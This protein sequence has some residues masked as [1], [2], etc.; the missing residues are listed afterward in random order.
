MNYFKF[1]RSN[2]VMVVFGIMMTALSSFGQTFLLALYVPFLISEFSLSNSSVSTFYGVATIVSAAMLPKVGKL[3]DNVPIKWF[4]IGATLLFCTALVT[5]SLAK[6]W[7]VIPISFL[8]LRL[9]GQGLYSH[10][11]ITAMSRYFEENRGKAISLAS[12]GHPLGQAVLPAIILM[13]IAKIGWRESLWLN[14]GLVTAVVISYTLFVLKEKHLQ[15][16]GGAMEIPEEKTQEKK[17]RQRDII[18]SKEFWLLAPN[19]FFIPFATTGLFFYQISIV[20]FKGW[21]E[22]MVAAGLSVYAIA[23][24]IS[25]LTAGPLID[26][27]RAKTFFPWYL[28]PFFIAILGLWL[29]P[30][31]W[32]MFVYM[33]LMGLSVGFGSA[34]LAALQVEFFGKKFIGSVRSIFT[35]IM[36]LSSALGPALYG[37]ILDA[38]LGWDVVLPINLI[39]LLPII[40]QSFRAMPGFTKAKWRFKYKRLKKKFGNRPV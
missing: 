31:I 36:V 27:Y 37:V 26:K 15:P 29:I 30:D 16:E 7:W 33:I 6:V 40:V 14:A 32:S 19:V 1:I 18:R 38:G 28:I 8:G 20:E 4:T 23:G 34:I 22:G 5:F 21:P 12:L 25:I 17:I 39:I 35:S 10:I 13:V 11:A 9:A 3:I 24:S 2:G